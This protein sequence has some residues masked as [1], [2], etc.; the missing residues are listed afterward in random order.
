MADTI[1]VVQPPAQVV[2]I[3][4]QGQG[5][6]GP[7]GADGHIG[8]DGLPGPVGPQGPPGLDGD[9]HYVHDQ[10]APQLVWTINHGMGKRPAV[11]VQDSGGT[12][13][14]GLVSYVSANVLTIEFSAAFSGTAYCN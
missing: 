10:M 5:P 4:N 1:T 6:A 13:V 9:K 14:E 12:E 7:P 11:S 2:T 8:V 3:L